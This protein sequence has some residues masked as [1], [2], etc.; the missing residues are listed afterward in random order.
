MSHPYLLKPKWTQCS[1]LNDGEQHIYIYKTIER[2]CIYIIY[3]HTH[4]SLTLLHLVTL[5]I[6]SDDH[7]ENSV[8]KNNKE[9]KNKQQQ[10]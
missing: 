2:G 6:Q 8:I 1:Y 4:T 3:I 7:H 5:L 9:N 10:K